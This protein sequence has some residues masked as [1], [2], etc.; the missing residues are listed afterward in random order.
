MKFKDQKERKCLGCGKTKKISEFYLIKNFKVIDSR[1]K[2]CRS[3][4]ARLKNKKK[5]ESA[6]RIFRPKKIY[7]ENS[8]YKI[9]T[10]CGINKPI[11]E[12][13]KGGRGKDGY[14]PKCKECRKELRGK[15]KESISEQ[16]LEWQRKN[17][18]HKT[19]YQKRYYKRTL[20]HRLHYKIR[21][22]S[23]Q[24]IHGMIRQIKNG[25]AY[26]NRNDFGYDRHEF[27]VN[28]ES[29]FKKGMSWKNWGEWHIDH[30]K[31]ISLFVSEGVKDLSIINALDNLQPLWAHE[32]MKKG[33]DYPEE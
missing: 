5:A 17:R 30:I 14:Q 23:V 15:N 12:Y 1:C 9:C 18:R 6:G 25:R 8:K 28:I 20:K 11:S 7:D 32:H 4:E 22:E 19:E 24:V 13:D 10:R 29:K 3:I 26:V 27:K 16:Q 2:K 33:I 31:P 21:T